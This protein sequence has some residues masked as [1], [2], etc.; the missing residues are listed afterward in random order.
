MT[1]I[2][3]T[4]LAQYLIEECRRREDLEPGLASLILD[5]AQACKTISRTVAFGSLGDARGKTGTVNVQGENQEALDVLSNEIFCEATNFG[6]QVAAIASEELEDILPV[7]DEYP[8]GDY[9]LVFDPLDGSS[10]IDVNVSVGSIFSILRHPRPGEKPTKE[11][12]LQP[13]H[14]QI[15]AGYAIFGP[16]TKLILTLG[17]GV[18]GFTMDPFQGDFYL[19]RPDLMVPEA[20]QEFAVNASNSRHWEAP[21]RRYVEECLAGKTGPRGK[22]FNMRWIASMVAEAHRILIRGGVFMY[23]RDNR[24]PQRS[25]RLRLMYEA[26]PVAFLMSQAGAMASTGAGSILDVQPTDLHQRVPLI[27]GSREEVERIEAYH[28][29]GDVEMIETPL[30]NTRGLFRDAS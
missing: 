30:F 10:N 6:G 19:T 16:S 27:F 8:M 21:V 13:G 26:N 5:V 23:P 9:L 22:D 18:Q 15:A 2:N 17:A 28:E 3:R 12:F 11:D 4:T 7:P 24:V 25:G 1:R 14:R 20:T 29:E